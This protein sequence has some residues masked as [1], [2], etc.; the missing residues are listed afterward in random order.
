MR[1]RCLVKTIHVQQLFLIN[2]P[3]SILH[4]NR[5]TTKNKNVTMATNHFYY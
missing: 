3:N 2:R 5:S 1:G 4:G